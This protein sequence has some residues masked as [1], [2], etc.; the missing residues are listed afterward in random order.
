MKILSV[1]GSPKGPSSNTDLI[2]KSFLEGAAQAGAAT[3]TIYL[4]DHII[5]HCLGCFNCWGKTA[6]SCVQDDDMAILLKKFRLADVIVYA[7]S[8]NHPAQR[9]AC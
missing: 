8:R 2:L 3:E 5:Q 9:E 1:N 6:G 7:T 4:K